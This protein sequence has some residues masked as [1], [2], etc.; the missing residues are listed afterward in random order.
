MTEFTDYADIALGGTAGETFTAY[1]DI[2]TAD[3]YML[4]TFGEA[5]DAWRALT[6]DDGEATKGRA[7]I[8]MTRILDRQKWKGT[9][10]DAANE[11]AFPREGVTDCD[12]NAVTDTAVPQ[13]I[14]DA[15]IEGAVLLNNGET[16]DTETPTQG[17]NIQRLD[18]KGV[19]I[20]YFRIG[21]LLGGAGGRFPLQ[22]MEI[23]G[24]LLAGAAGFV[25]IAGATASGTWGCS[26]TGRRYGF[27]RGL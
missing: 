11:H 12:G 20:S 13:Q 19:S 26:V 23:M 18:A 17:N 27:T 9:K 22:L 6:G 3:A 8:T 24:C 10:T 15:T 1:A 2:A 5:A 16:F 25:G 4:G 7:L 14:V 21:G